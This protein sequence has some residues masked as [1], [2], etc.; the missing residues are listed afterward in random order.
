MNPKTLLLPA[1]FLLA[2]GGAQ[3]AAITPIVDF[4]PGVSL[5]TTGLA[6]FTTGGAD[7][8]G[9]LVTAY[10]T[11][12]SSESAIWS[13]TAPNTGAAA[14]TGWSLSMSGVSSYSSPWILANRSTAALTRIVIDGQPGSTIFDTA[15]EDYG[16]PGLN[17]LTPGSAQG[18]PMSSLEGP[19]GLV[20]NATYRNQVGLNNVI[21]GDLFTVLDIS[22][23]D[24][25]IG[26]L[27]YI[28]DTDNTTIRGDI[29]NIPEPGTFALAALG[30]SGLLLGHRR[31]TPKTDA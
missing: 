14:G 8:S 29:T 24:G 1:L 11:G 28:A 31:T 9:T 19:E 21:Y 4:L 26:E 15:L 18:I 6:T 10:F 20:I 17:W 7:M 3:A 27:S 30:L 12:G 13:T 2:T 25:L 23:I 22:F 16:L 5:N